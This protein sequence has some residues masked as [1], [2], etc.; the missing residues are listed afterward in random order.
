MS[1]KSPNK[2]SAKGLSKDN[3]KAHSKDHMYWSRRDF[4]R[5]MGV[6]TS[7]GMLMGSN[8]LHAYTSLNNNY[9]GQTENIVVLIRLVGGNDGLNTIVPLY[10][11]GRYQQLRP[12]LAHPQNELINLSD[13]F[14]IPQ[15]ASAFMDLWQDG[16]MKVIHGV[17]YPEQNL[18]HFR[19]TDIWSTAEPQEEVTSGWLGKL[20]TLDDPD[21]SVDPPDHPAA[22]QIGNSGN[23]TFNDPDNVNL[24]FQVSNT[25]QLFQIAEEGLFYPVNGLPDCLHGEQLEYVRNIANSTFR[26]A[27]V[28]KQ[29]YEGTG[30]AVQYTNSSLANQLA[31]VARLIKGGLRTSFYMVNLGSF[32]THANQPNTHDNLLRWLSS[33]VKEFYQDLAAGGAEQR[34][35]SMTTSEFGRRPQQNASNGTDHGAAAP[36]ML[37]GPALEG[38]GFIGTHPDL[39]DLDHVNNLKYSTDFRQVYQALMTDWLCFPTTEVEDVIGESFESMELGFSCRGT[40]TV[41]SFYELGAVKMQ[42]HNP[43]HFTFKVDIPQNLRG[44]AMVYDLQGKLVARLFRG[45]MMRGTNQ[46]VLQTERYQ[47]PAGLY[48]FLLRAGSSQ[49]KKKFMVL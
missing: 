4:M 16:Q 23:L 40:R 45:S 28:I 33:N 26:Y 18:S 43:R 41:S 7:V 19:S 46:F 11:Y 8:P 48:I 9:T 12:S 32:D 35:L 15:S 49:V 42:T 17:G 6:T 1:K 37:F 36:Q 3:K 14:A 5:T 27:D 20:I 10:D 39:N 2:R 21:I 29:A 22:I 31:I 25:D 38:N 30:N 44:E 24:S 47:M 13:E 34:V